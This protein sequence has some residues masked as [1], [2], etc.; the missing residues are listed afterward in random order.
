MVLNIS[1]SLYWLH[2]LPIL[3]CL[4]MSFAHFYTRLF[5]LVLLMYSSFSHGLGKF[6]N[7]TTWLSTA[8]LLYIWLCTL[9]QLIT[10]ICILTLLKS[11][12]KDLSSVLM[13]K[14]QLLA[15]FIFDLLLLM[16]TA[17]IFTLILIITFYFL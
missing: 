13:S 8:F 3:K 4:F 16:F 12:S 5:V 1:S 7:V 14:G 11:F 6:Q 15:L 17:L 10:F 2:G 9:L